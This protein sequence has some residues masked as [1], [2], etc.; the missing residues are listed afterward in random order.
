MIKLKKIILKS[1]VRVTYINTNEQIDLDVFNTDQT[2]HEKLRIIDYLR[3]LNFNSLLYVYKRLKQC[4]LE[5]KHNI[6]I[7][8]DGIKDN[9]DKLSDWSENYIFKNELYLNKIQDFDNPIQSIKFYKELV[10]KLK[11][12]GV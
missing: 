4:L 2:A 3:S 12:L 1:M 6:K 9:E 5:D 8:R 10:K 7:I 11:S